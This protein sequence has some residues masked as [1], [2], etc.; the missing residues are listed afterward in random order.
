MNYFNI[1]MYVHLAINS[2][3]ISSYSVFVWDINHMV[4]CASDNAFMWCAQPGLNHSSNKIKIWINSWAVEGVV[5]FFVANTFRMCIFMYIYVWNRVLVKVWGHV[6]ITNARHL[7][8]NKQVVTGRPLHCT[9]QIRKMYYII[10]ICGA[11]S[12][13]ET[14]TNK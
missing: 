2:R 12:Q 4:A 11:N 10:N 9:L 1:H 14:R 5:Q 3:T 8:V 7:W 6:K 13:I